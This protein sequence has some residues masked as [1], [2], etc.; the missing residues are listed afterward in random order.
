M[1]INT[2]FIITFPP[3]TLFRDHPDAMGISETIHLPK[4]S[5]VPDLAVKTFAALVSKKR[6]GQVLKNQIFTIY[7]KKLIFQ[8]PRPD[9]TAPFS[10][11]P[12]YM[13]K[14]APIRTRLTDTA[15]SQPNGS[16]G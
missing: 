6:K 9:P 13:Q 7:R 1:N 8:D 10:C 11:Q 5:T 12:L 15:F 3:A 4:C 14:A 16:S 2:L